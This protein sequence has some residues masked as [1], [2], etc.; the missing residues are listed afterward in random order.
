[1]SFDTPEIA[2]KAVDAWV[3]R[4]KTQG[5]VVY[6]YRD[7]ARL[8]YIG[9]VSPLRELVAREAKT[10]GQAQAVADWIRGSLAAIGRASPS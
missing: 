6:H 5:L 9:A 1:M 8:G 3:D 2:P 10:G 7:I 4:L